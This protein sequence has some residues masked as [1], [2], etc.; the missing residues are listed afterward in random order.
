MM[1]RT[2]NIS[3][4][5]PA[6]S[7]S[8]LVLQHLSKRFGAVQALDDVSLTLAA[9]SIHALVG[10]NGAG[11]STLVKIL[12]GVVRPDG[13]QVLL[14]GRP[15]LL[16]GP[17]DARRQGIA[18][19]HQ[20][21][22]LFPDLSVMENVFLADPPRDRWGRVDYREM[23]QRVASLFDRL[24]VELDPHA[25]VRGLSMAD[26]QLIE[27]A[28]ALAGRARVLI[29]DEPTASLSA[30]EVQRLFA[31]VEQLRDQGVAILFVSHRLDEIFRLADTITVLRDGRH[32]RTAPT[33]ELT[34]ADVVRHMVGRA[35]EGTN[36]SASR[37]RGPVVLEVQGLTRR[38]AFND[39]SFALHQGE[40]LGMAGLVGAGRTEVARV[41]FGI[42]RPDFGRMWLEG[43]E[44]AV[45]SPATALEMGI[46]YVPE[47]RHQQGLVLPFSITANVSL[48]ILHRL[49]PRGVVRPVRE[50]AL[51][52]RYR[53]ELRIR[54]SGVDQPVSD[55]SGGNQQKVVLAKWLATQPK[56][57]ILDEPTRGIDV[58]AKAE[59]HRIVE[60]LASQGLAILLI[61]SD[62]PEVLALS[63]RILVMYEGRVT[64]I[65][66]RQEA[67]EERVM[68]A[69]SG[70]PIG[71]QAGRSH[72]GWTQA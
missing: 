24:G 32:V 43:R 58:G 60:H 2:E 61:S 68:A 5:A 11:K 22:S 46:A 8:L 26:Q 6:G 7:P 13:G 15:L 3:P 48:P 64:A 66:S 39:V 67:S 31:L 37:S 36:A 40:I 33:K 23:R 45:G 49:F 55:L 51:A 54:S 10:E 25:E 57:L 53:S 59:V 16:S 41:L 65:F 21:P 27:I 18:V 29:M 69:A 17:A 14:E 38:G 19:I 35:L 56:V 47:D 28:K 62:L 12:S 4:I 71:A 30:H 52:Q 20:E 44:V 34:P 1:E 42:D 70:S 63:D 72:G 9:G 50:R